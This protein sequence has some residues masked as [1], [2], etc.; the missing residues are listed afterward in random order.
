MTGWTLAT[1]ARLGMA[2]DARASLAPIDIGRAN[3]GEIRNA[4]AVICLAEGNP[5]NA[6]GALLPVLDGTARVIHQF[7]AVEAHLVAALA[8]PRAR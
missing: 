7:T 2:G 4:R 1:Q 8:P 3:S 5:L 6:L